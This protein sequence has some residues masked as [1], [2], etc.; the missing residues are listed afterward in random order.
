MEC[1]DVGLVGADAARV[2]FFHFELQLLEQTFLLLSLHL[3]HVVQA[4]LELQVGLFLDLFLDL[5]IELR[6]LILEQLGLFL[7]LVACRVN[8]LL[9]LLEHL[10]GILAVLY[11]RQVLLL[12]LQEDV[13]QLVR[14]G[15]VELHV[16]L[17]VGLIVAG[18]SR[19]A[20][21]VFLDYIEVVTCCL[22]KQ[23][24]VVLRRWTFARNWKGA[25]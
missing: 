17:F 24:R 16:E 9:E 3:A 14:I 12:E 2:D 5:R 19:I 25:F 8:R 10:L 15:E 20:G 23:T 11:E 4:D 1:A 21:L 18:T 7:H 6:D 22:A 13:Q